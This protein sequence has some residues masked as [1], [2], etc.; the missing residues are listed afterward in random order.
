MSDS[1]LSLFREKTVYEQI[2]VLLGMAGVFL[3]MGLA[4][5]LF[6]QSFDEQGDEAAALFEGQITSAPSTLRQDSSIVYFQVRL[7]EANFR[8]SSRQ[9]VYVA[10]ELYQEAG[11]TPGARVD[12]YASG[13][14]DELKIH[15]VLNTDGRVVFDEQFERQITS[16]KNDE[17]LRYFSFFMILTLVCCSSAGVLW[18]RHTRLIQ[19]GR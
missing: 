16:I 10:K 2:R 13:G 19:A 1:W 5:L 17:L 15:K 14:G 11:L 8:P 12:V 4:F 6:V 3:L 18:F 7:T 9:V